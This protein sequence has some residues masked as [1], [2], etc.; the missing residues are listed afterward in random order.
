MST[1][2]TVL[3]DEPAANRTGDPVPERLREW[4]AVGRPELRRARLLRGAAQSGTVVWAGGPAW[5]AGRRGRPNAAW[6]R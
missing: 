1:A 4:T 3:L 6:A 2:P 5:T